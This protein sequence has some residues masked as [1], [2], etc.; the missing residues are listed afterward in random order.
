[1]KFLPLIFAIFCFFPYLDFLGLGTDTQPNALIAGALILLLIKDK[2]I[3]LPIILLWILFIFSLFLFLKNELSTFEYLKNALNYL[4]PALVATTTY[5]LFKRNQLKISYRFMLVTIM[6]YIFFG[7]M[8]MFVSHSFGEILLNS[9]RGV[10]IH[11]RG[12]V[13][14][15]PEPAF[16]GSITLFFLA[17]SLLHFN[18]EQNLIIAPLLV[19]QLLFLSMS[20]TGVA[21]L[22]LSLIVFAAVQILKL[23]LS[24]IIY[25][26]IFFSI[27]IPIYKAQIEELESTR[28]GKLAAD[29]IKD[30]VAVT[31]LDDSVGIRF[32]GAVAP[33]LSA[34][35]KRLTP[36]GIGNYKNFLSDLYS[37]G[38]HR[39]FLNP[40]IINQKEKL[41]G[42]LNMVLFQLGYFGILFPL[43][44]YL[45]FRP[46]LSKQKYLFTCILF[47]CLLCT[48]LQLMHSFIGFF[49]GYVMYKTRVENSSHVT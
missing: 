39:N 45:T 2:R 32:A 17:F 10:L 30:P 9:V 11:G 14:L 12:V 49:M 41:G 35:H 21:I 43:A 44:I 27:S 19:G 24:Y 18:R 26:A 22:L 31:Q 8:Q 3:T 15:C 28:M 46:K 38:E 4:S 16:Y 7:L 36:M 5:I 23:R 6:I 40:V 1:M 20:A 42:S 47:C 37:K 34:K 13:S 25:A 29:F 48:Q 33:F